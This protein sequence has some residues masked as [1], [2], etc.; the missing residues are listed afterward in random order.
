M[1]S[2]HVQCWTLDGITGHACCWRSS[3]T[4]RVRE[5]YRGGK[6]GRGPRAPP[7]PRKTLTQPVLASSGPSMVHLMLSCLRSCLFGCKTLFR[8][9]LWCSEFQCAVLKYLDALN[10]MFFLSFFLE[11][12]AERCLSFHPSIHPSADRRLQ[13]RQVKIRTPAQAKTKTKHKENKIY[14]SWRSCSIPPLAS[15]RLSVDRALSS[16]HFIKTSSNLPRKSP[17]S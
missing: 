17:I 13:S 14:S 8:P 2:P 10:S 11:S 16:P 3:G 9:T 4:D 1:G 15:G 7:T 12:I 5:G 6:A